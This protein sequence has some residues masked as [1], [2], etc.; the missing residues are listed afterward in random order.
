MRN[1]LGRFRN[2]IRQE[3][4]MATQHQSFSR[5]GKIVNY[6]PARHSVRVQLQPEGTMTGYIPLEEPW[7]G[8]GWGMYC[9]PAIGTIVEVQFLQGS[10][11]SGVAGGR[12]Y[13]AKTQP[14]A[15]PSGEFWLV[16]K[17]GQ[18]LKFL[19]DGT[20]QTN[21]TWN[22]TGDLH[23]TGNITATEDIT[24]LVG[25][26]NESMRSMRAIYDEHVHPPGNVTPTPQM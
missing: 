17:N 22:H 1:L 25:T 13:S 24:D 26:V 6:D 2:M 16:H 7:V 14:L 18:V 4:Q 10:K 15:V 11:Q 12:Y 21:G 23:V 5:A 8:D 20:I 9:A 3:A 19:N